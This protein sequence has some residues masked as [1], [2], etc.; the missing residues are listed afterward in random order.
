M[1]KSKKEVTSPAGAIATAKTPFPKG[2]ARPALRA[3]A[4]AGYQN[5]EQLSSATEASLLALHGFGP[6]AL[7]KL[8]AA[9]QELGLSFVASDSGTTASVPAK[10]ADLWS[11][12]AEVQGK[13]FQQ[14]LA[15]TSEPV[16]W[17]YA[18]WDDL[19]KRLTDRNN[20]SRSIA[21]QIVCNL[22]KSDPS[23]RMLR[24][25][26]ALFAVT[27]DERFVTA[28]HCLQSLWKVGCVDKEYQETLVSALETHFSDC[29]SH[30]NCTLIRYDIIESLR[31]LFDAVHDTDIKS[32]AL[33]LIEL[34]SDPKYK[35]KYMK[36]WPKRSS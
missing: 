35:N 8:R 9:L 14:V 25:F 12:D 29:V 20:R 11:D 27:R 18:V 23:K 24:D 34:E 31:K 32:R 4:R 36:L 16:G 1:G 17:A 6:N 26:D 10:F 7:A 3:L 2:L 19:L 5:L 30:K 21:A 13:A 28:R 33:A 22:A 15:L